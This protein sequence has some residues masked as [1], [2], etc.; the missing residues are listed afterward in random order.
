MTNGQT[1]FTFTDATWAVERVKGD[2]IRAIAVTS[3]RR[4]SVMP[5][6][7]TLAE[8]GLPG[9]ELEP[10]WGVFAPAGTPQ[11]VIDKLAAAFDRIM[12]MP[13]TTAFLHRLANEPFPGTPDSLRVLLA[14]EIERWGE[15]IKLAN[16]PPQ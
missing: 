10:W 13:E 5:D 12:A 8:Q 1:D 4:S 16:I 2:R 3:A 15:L 9:I 14:K 6:V 7:P 11:P